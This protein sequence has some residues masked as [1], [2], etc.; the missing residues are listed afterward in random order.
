MSSSNNNNKDTC[1]PD[2]KD[3][4]VLVTGGA[5]GIGAGCCEAFANIGN[6][7]V[8]C[9][10]KN[11]SEP[12]SSL[13]QIQQNHWKIKFYHCDVSNSNQ[14]Q[15]IMTK[16]H[17][18]YPQ[19][20]DILINNVGIQTD[21]GQPCH[22]LDE[23]IWDLVM[24]VNV[25]SYFLFS[26]YCLPKMLSRCQQQQEEEGSR[27]GGSGVIINIASVQGLQSQKGIPA[28]A[29]SK[30]AILSFTRQLAMEYAEY[31]IRVVAVNPGTIKTPLVEQILMNRLKEADDADNNDGDNATI[32]STTE[33][34]KKAGECY[35]MKRC[36]E[37]S[38]V[39]QVVLFLASNRASFITGESINVDGGIMSKGGWA[40]DC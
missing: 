6:C 9:V 21:D 18:D 34:W 37:I 16:I 13:D 27:S 22:L 30:G 35:P 29:A 32:P 8:I 7:D 2:L 40:D 19:G 4:V 26:K 39:A 31:G 14:I 28:Y 17:K 38:E 1:Y 33:A 23:S 11:I 12:S 5:N 3:K 20:I 24:N 15:N 25:K 10:D 36:G